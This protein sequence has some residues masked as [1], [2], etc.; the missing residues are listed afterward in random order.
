MDGVK[1]EEEKEEEKV[2]FSNKLFECTTRKE[3]NEGWR[4][5]WSGED[6]GKKEKRW[7]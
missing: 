7:R 6:L 5:E 4:Q 2:F 3:K 1:E